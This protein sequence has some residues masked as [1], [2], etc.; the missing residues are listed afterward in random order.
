VRGLLAQANRTPPAGFATATVPHHASP[1]PPTSMIPYP[2]PWRRPATFRV[3]V[4]VAAV[5]IAAAAFVGGF[6]TRG[7]VAAPAQSTRP[8]A[9]DTTI[10]HGERGMLPE[11][12]WN[13]YPEGACVNGRLAKG[14]RIT[15]DA[16]VDCTTP[17]DLQFYHSETQLRAPGDYEDFPNP[18]YPDPAV[19]TAYT[20]NLCTLVFDSKWLTDDRSGLHYRAIIPTKEEWDAD[21]SVSC[22]LYRADGKQL[23]KSY[24]A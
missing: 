23:T 13:S 22:V 9:M 12:S 8:A 5:A 14:Q 10:T 7:V 17:H 11:L 2:T 21:R 1:V 4:V 18:A 3:A 24:V 19:L 16:Q 6:F 20:E 15:A